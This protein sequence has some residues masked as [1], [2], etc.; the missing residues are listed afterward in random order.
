VGLVLLLLLNACST[1]KKT[2]ST[3]N[4]GTRPPTQLPEPSIP[5][6][7]E[8]LKDT[9]SQIP[10]PKV[11]TVFREPQPTTPAK[12]VDDRPKKPIKIIPEITL[13]LPLDGLHADFTSAPDP[14]RSRFIQFYAGASLAMQ[15]LDSS[16]LRI[17]LQS[18]DTKVSS[19]F[20][21]E[22]TERDQLKTCDVIVGPYDKEEIDLVAAYG[23]ENETM[24]LSPWMPA[25]S[26]EKDNPFFIQMNSGL[27]TH[28]EAIIQ[29][30]EAEWPQEKVYIVSRDNAAELNR[31]Q[32]FK[33]SAKGDIE[34]LIIKDATPDLINTNLHELMAETGKTIFI[35]P[36]YLKSDETFVNSFLR[37]LHADK[38]TREVII[39]GLPQWLGYTNLNPNYLESLSAH[40]S[41]SSFIDEHHPKY[42]WFR[43]KFF[44]TYHYVP[45]LNA[46]QGYDMVL[47]LAHQLKAAGQEGLIGTR[48]PEWDGM[49]MGFDILPVYKT[50][51]SASG[52]MHTP[53]YYENKQIRIVRFSQQDYHI[54]R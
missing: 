41:M 40:L 22:L 8:E 17:H 6:P 30:I 31:I 36:Y 44:N 13:L 10:S 25:Y 16:G 47:W 2:S 38:D 32:S 20:L 3:S 35:L 27:T 24:V 5:A 1:S 54:V 34:D 48:N 46:Y 19:G 50:G 11:D 45:D 37:K 18:Y 49:S 9:V 4:T 29:F 7:Q 15:Y 39:F 43:T 21:N 42:D 28:A 26:P 53:A 23:L 51:I 52:E 33:K 12:E 14:K